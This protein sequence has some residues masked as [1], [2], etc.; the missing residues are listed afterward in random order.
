VVLERQTCLGKICDFHLSLVGVGGLGG[1]FNPTLA[2][3][4]NRKLE[5]KFQNWNSF[6]NVALE[7]K[8]PL[9]ASSNKTPVHVT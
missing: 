3:N 1:D 8:L 7:V 6:T 2:L 4:T 9:A 5:I